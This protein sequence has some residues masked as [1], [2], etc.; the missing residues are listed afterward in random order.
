MEH[1]KN[2]IAK[3]GIGQNAFADRIGVSRGYLSLILARRRK[4]SR[5]MIEKIAAETG[6]AVPPSVWFEQEEGAA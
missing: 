1:L 3:V 5:A 4:P 2:H 6:G